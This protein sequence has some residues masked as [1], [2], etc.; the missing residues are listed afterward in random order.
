M[1]VPKPVIT[2]EAGMVGLV[3]GLFTVTTGDTD[4][5]GVALGLL[6]FAHPAAVIKIIIVAN[7]IVAVFFMLYLLDIF[8]ALPKRRVFIGKPRD[9]SG[10]FQAVLHAPPLYLKNRPIFTALKKRNYHYTNS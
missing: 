8:I 4:G 6:L 5:A 10:C 7:T 3:V 1:S 9:L 2:L